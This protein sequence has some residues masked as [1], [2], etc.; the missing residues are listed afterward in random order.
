MSDLVGN[1][2]DRFSH[3]E[4]QMLGMLEEY[5][6]SD[7]KA[8]VPTLVHAYNATVH[9]SSG[10]FLYFLMFG[11]H[12]HLVIDAFLGLTPDSISAKLQTEDA[13]KLKGRLHFA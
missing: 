1:S 7:W 8:H 11:C 13:R 10:Y 6:K 5:Q 3:N 2:E 4:A 9:D 12:P